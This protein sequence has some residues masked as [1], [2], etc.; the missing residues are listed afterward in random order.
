MLDGVGGAGDPG[1]R[2]RSTWIA[3]VLVLMLVFGRADAFTVDATTD[4]PDA[5]PGNGVCASSSNACTLRAAI[6]ET[7]AGGGDGTIDVPAGTYVLT[8]GGLSVTKPL[9]LTGAGRSATIIDGNGSVT[10]LGVAGFP[11]TIRAVTVRH[12]ARGI[13]P[14]APQ[15]SPLVIEDAEVSGHTGDGVTGACC[16][17]VQVTRSIV[18]ANGG[19]GVNALGPFMAVEDSVIRAN[20]GGGIVTQAE[21][22]TVDRSEIVANRSATDGGGIAMGCGQLAVRDSV[23]TA[24]VADRDG[25]GIAQFCGPRRTDFFPL[26]AVQRTVVSDNVA[27]GDGGGLWVFRGL[28]LAESAVRGNRATNGGGV[29]SGSGVAPDLRIVDSELSENHAT[30]D[31]GGLHKTV[32][33]SAAWVVNTTISGNVADGAGGGV[34]ATGAEMSRLSF[35]NVTVAHNNADG[36]SDGA[37]DGGGIAASVAEVAFANSI[38]GGNGDAGGQAPDCA[39]AVIAT[40]PNLVERTLGCAITGTTIVSGVDPRLAPLDDHGGPTRTHALLD[41]SPALDAGDGAGCADPDG[42]LLA[43]DQRGAP[44]PIGVRCDLGAVEAGC[45]NGQVDAGEACDPAVAMDG[46]CTAVCRLAGAGEACADD[47]QTCT[48]DVCD[49]RGACRH[50]VPI[51]AGCLPAA[52]GR[53]LV[54]LKDKGDPN[55]DR[56][57][58]SWRS[59]NAVAN[60]AFGDP[61]ADTRL[62]LCVFA[63]G[64]NDSTLKLSAALPAGSA[65][66]SRPCW[67]TAP[68]GFRYLDN[69]LTANGVHRLLLRPSVSGTS[70]IIL[71]G[72]GGNLHMPALGGGDPLVVRL[73]RRDGG[74]CWEARFSSPVR[75][76]AIR[77]A[78][79]S[80]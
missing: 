36:D 62:D 50:T 77:F 53:S 32:L 19:I 18:R 29:F 20:G 7:N 56:I 68:G 52:E 44:R 35:A 17:S 42:M 33:G 27:G 45:G 30:A 66:G 58:W 34:F 57:R 63:A 67:S 55:E 61:A 39:G 15:N 69:T 80:D 65:C 73:Q 28:D 76:D 78:G 5:N 11:T 8:R 25:G 59:A 54:S 60:G 79:R 64:P 3:P 74:G 47:G 31:G 37:G 23:V 12:G 24:N 9:E 21:G 6:E 2:P 10:V 75:N 49:G 72:R 4:D 41:A 48:T 16:S 71:R 51:D 43:G 26:L 13:V 40:G 38:L 70:H 14:T 1:S 22:A 46:C